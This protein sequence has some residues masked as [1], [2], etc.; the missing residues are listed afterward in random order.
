[1]VVGQGTRLFPDTGPDTALELV[2]SRATPAGD[3]PGLPAHRAPAVRN[4]HGRHEHMTQASHHG[5]QTT[6]AEPTDR[7]HRCRRLDSSIDPYRDT[8][9]ALRPD[10]GVPKRSPQVVAPDEVRAAAS[11]AYSLSQCASSSAARLRRQAL[12]ALPF[13]R[14]A[15]RGAK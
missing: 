15:I 3:D 2:E 1:V 7:V 14:G 9:P 10:A 5:G 13:R 6:A 12:I 11:T 8:A 4:G